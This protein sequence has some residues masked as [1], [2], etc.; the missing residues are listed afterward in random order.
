MYSNKVVTVPSENGTFSI[1]KPDFLINN[2]SRN[3][4]FGTIMSVFIFY[5]IS[6]PKGIPIDKKIFKF[7][8]ISVF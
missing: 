7:R 1:G 8:L 3:S 2:L 4:A 6:F 5:A